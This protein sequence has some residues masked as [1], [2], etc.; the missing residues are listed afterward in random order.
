MMV[1]W[2]LCDIRHRYQLHGSDGCLVC[3]VEYISLSF[4]LYNDV[5]P[6]NMCRVYT[7]VRC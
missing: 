6:S 4:Y 3:I 1:V 5:L 2:S 7:D